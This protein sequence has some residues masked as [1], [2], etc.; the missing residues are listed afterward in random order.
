[1][2]V[3]FNT[4]KDKPKT[5]SKEKNNVCKKWK[6]NLARKR[7]N[8]KWEVR[9]RGKGGPGGHHVPKEASCFCLLG[10]SSFL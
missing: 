1:M 5:W 6:E 10:L 3:G 7:G 9:C 8:T 2:P 4:W